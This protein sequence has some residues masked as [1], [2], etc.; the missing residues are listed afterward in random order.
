MADL[1]KNYLN[2]QSGWKSWFFS[3]DHKRISLLYMYS[4]FSFFLLGGVFAILMRLELFSV[5]KTIVDSKMYNQFM[6]LHGSI[7]VFMVIIPGIPAFLGN[8]LLP[9]QIGAKDVAFPRLNLLSWYLL[10]IGSF[11]ALGVFIFQWCGYRLDF[12]HTL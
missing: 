1:S 3:L 4:I 11:I 9:L 8:F 10:M 2:W 7:M 12:L 5:G 6:T